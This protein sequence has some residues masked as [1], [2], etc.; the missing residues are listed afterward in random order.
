MTFL[1]E[2]DLIWSPG[3]AH[4][5]PL[6]GDKHEESFNASPA[7]PPQAPQ[8]NF[9]PLLHGCFSWSLFMGQAHEEDV[10]ETVRKE[11][12]SFSFA[13]T[14]LAFWKNKNKKK[15]RSRS[16]GP[17]SSESGHYFGWSKN[18]LKMDGLFP[19]LQTKQ[20]IK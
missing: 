12:T 15:E 3:D 6:L 2:H 18:H 13:S 14:R 7:M 1:K 19:T 5:S 10:V 4:F 17:I 16:Q 9:L 8:K 20:N 11:N